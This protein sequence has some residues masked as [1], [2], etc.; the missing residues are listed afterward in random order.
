[1]REERERR[2]VHPLHVV[3]HEQHRGIQRRAL[4]QLGDQLEHS[5]ATQVRIAP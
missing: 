4:E 3:D 5:L 1:M 2:T